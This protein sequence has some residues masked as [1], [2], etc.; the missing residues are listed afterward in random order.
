MTSINDL[1]QIQT[2]YLMKRIPPFELSYETIAH[3]KVF[4][5]YNLG[6]AIPSGKKCYAYFSF[7]QQYD[8]CYLM[9]MN[10][11]KKITKISTVDTQF[12]PELSLGTMLYGTILQI[13]EQDMNQPYIGRT[14]FIIEDIFYYKGLSLKNIPFGEKL[15]YIENMMKKHIVQKFTTS[16]SMIFALP[17]MWGIS[18]EEKDS[19][20]EQLDAIKNTLFYLV[21]HIQIRKLNEISPY[22]NI[23]LNNLVSKIK[24]NEKILDQKE[25][26]IKNNPIVLLKYTLDF[27]KPQYKYP[28]IFQVSADI[29]FDIYH[30]FAYGK[31]KNS[32]YYGIAC[33]PNIE[34]SVFMNSLF[35]NIKENKNIDYIEESEDESDF[36]NTSEDKYVDLNK[37]YNIECSFNNKFKKWVPIRVINEP[38]KVVHIS[39]LVND[40]I[41]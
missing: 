30:L 25:P 12:D 41:L 11:E 6:I 29:Q 7:Q 14:V 22:L 28:T 21:H 40:Y 1:T 36:E 16:E 26:I 39:K 13:D 33:I 18:N 23:T 37:T 34:T 27:H 4:P 2:Q 17:V 31:N 9:E 35:R 20:V 19:I 10:R 32:V 8:V 38:N 24:S 5:S 3:K 15:G